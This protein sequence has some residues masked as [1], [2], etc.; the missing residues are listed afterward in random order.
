MSG[1]V[2]TLA[3]QEALARRGFDPGPLDGL[4]GRRTIAALRAFQGAEGLAPTGLVDANT[5]RALLGDG[6]DPEALPDAMPWIDQARRMRGLHERV[7]NDALRTF[8]ASDGGSVG[9]PAMVPW[10]ADFVQT[11]LALTLPD[12]PLP[13][14]PYASISWMRFGIPVPLRPG[15]VVCLWR[16]SPDDWKGHV[17]FCVEATGDGILILGGNQDDSISEKWVDRTF[18]RRDGSRWPLTA[19]MPGEDVA[20]PSPDVRSREGT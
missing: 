20:A 14:D 11:C 2:T 3:V 16:D 9:D 7:H 8:L 4:R 18:L 5:A 1:P 6:V 17:G 10:C 13:T 12:E 19:L 15:A